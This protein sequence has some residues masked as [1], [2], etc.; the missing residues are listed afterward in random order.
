MQREGCWPVDDVATLG[1]Q[2]VVVSPKESGIFVLTQ[3]P[4]TCGRVLVPNEVT[5]VCLW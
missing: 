5:M 1:V 3:I 4:P 2:L